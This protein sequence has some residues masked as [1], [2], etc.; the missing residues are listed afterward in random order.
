EQIVRHLRRKR[1][2][3]RVIY[4]HAA[5][6]DILPVR[7]SKGTALRYFAWKWGI[8]LDRCLAAGASASDE[9]M[10]TGETFAVVVAGHDPT[11]DKLRGHPR[12]YFSEGGHAYGIIEAIGHYDFLGEPRAPEEPAPEPE[13]ELV[14]SR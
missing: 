7:A 13:P 3:A 6:L 2:T 5:F 8:P 11:L 9:D 12:I 14:G 4:S 10:L 1:V